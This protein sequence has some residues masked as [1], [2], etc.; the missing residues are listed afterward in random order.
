MTVEEILR[1]KPAFR[2][3]YEPYS[4]STTTLEPK[5]CGFLRRLQIV[6]AKISAYLDRKKIAE[7]WKKIYGDLED[8]YYIIRATDG[9]LFHVDY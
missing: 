5:G 2:C 6:P 4:V 9:T 1:P 3:G 7:V 8:A